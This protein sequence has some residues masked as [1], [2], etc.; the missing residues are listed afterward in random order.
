ASLSNVSLAGINAGSYPTSVGASFAGDSSDAT[1]SGTGGLTVNKAPLAVTVDNKSK[2]Y[3]AANPTLTGTATGVMSGDGIT[4]SYS[5]GATQSSGVGGYAIT[6][7]LNDPN[8]KLGNYTV[9]NTPGTLTVNPATLTVTA[10]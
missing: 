10:S 6:A 4:A 3:G 7:V 1:S 8:N 9:T 2:V 5:T